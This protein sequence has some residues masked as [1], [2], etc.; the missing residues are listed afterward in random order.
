MSFLLYGA[1][2]YTGRLIAERAVAQGVR[3]ILAGRDPDRLAALAGELGLERRAVSLDDAAALKLALT[4]VPLVLHAAGPFSRTSRP[5]VDACLHT[6]THYLDI[7]GEIAVFEALA[8]R[9]TEAERAGITVLPGVGFDVV[10]T[11]C[12]AMHLHRRLPS[13]TRLR[14]AIRALGSA[15]RGTAKTAVENAGSGGAARVAGE[16]VTVP[17]AHDQITVAFP[18]GKTRTC[19][20][21]PWGDVSTAFHS[22]GIPNVT[23]YAALPPGAVRAMKASRY[24]GAILQTRP[25]QSLLGA[26]VDRRV[27]GPSEDDRQRGRSFVWGEATDGDGNRVVSRWEGPEG[28]AFTVDAA[29]RAALAVLEG[30]AAPGFQT[31]SLAFGP[32]F[33]L[34]TEGTAREDV[35]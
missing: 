17:P 4:S 9:S 1:Y 27:T 11:D 18:D 34:E 5:M 30:R 14:L 2:G 26:I 10:P 6:R 28:Y 15:S 24:L 21:I 8:A 13:A 23:T 22:T 19:T 33:A 12:L 16:I 3:P 35:A 7:T 31:P 20:A 32:D 29:L 25:V